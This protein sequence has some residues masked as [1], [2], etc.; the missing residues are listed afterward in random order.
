M[1]QLNYTRLF[2][3]FEAILEGSELLSNSQKNLKNKVVVAVCITYHW[4]N[5][6]T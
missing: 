5:A 2:F 1:L 6:K 3:I 4:H